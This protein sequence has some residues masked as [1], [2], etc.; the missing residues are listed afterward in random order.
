MIKKCQMAH[1]PFFH[2]SVEMVRFHSLCY[3]SSAGLANKQNKHVLVAPTSKGAPDCRRKC[4]HIGN[5][6]FKFRDSF[7]YYQKFARAFGAREKLLFRQNI[8][9]L[10]RQIRSSRR[11]HGAK[12]HPPNLS[13]WQPAWR[14]YF[15]CWLPSPAIHFRPFQLLWGPYKYSCL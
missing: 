15:S 2:I 9:S 13:I 7:K 8:A 5:V 11:G 14:I 6:I 12:L 1:R 4:I 10:N 3:T